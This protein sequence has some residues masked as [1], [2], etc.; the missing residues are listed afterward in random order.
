VEALTAAPVVGLAR[1]LH[2]MPPAFWV[3][4]WGTLVNRVGSFVT[5]F[6]ALYLTGERSFTVAEAGVVLSVLGA[7]SAISQPL[8]GV[9]A[10]RI[11]RRRTMVLG[12]S[13]AAGTLLLLGAARGWG[14][15]AT[16]AFAYGLCL[17]L[18]RPAVGAAVADLVP[19]HDRSRAFA[20]QFWAINLGFS[21]ATPLGG[22][23]ASRGYWLLFVLD[24]AASL[25]FAALILRGVPETRPLQ[26][27][28][29]GRLADAMRD[30]LLLALL[31]CS[32]AQATASFQTFVTLP[33]SFRAD[34][35]GPGTY[36]LAIALNGVMIIL[37]Q[38]LLLGTVQRRGRGG[39]LLTAL[40]LQ[41]VGLGMHALAEDVLGHV[42]AIFV[43]TLGEVLMAG[44]LGALVV[45]LAPLRVRGRYLGAFGS[46][47]GVAA[48]L[49][50]V[51]GTQ[52]LDR[53]GE[54]GLWGGA[55][56]VSVLAGFGLR[57]VSA[58]ADRRGPL[59]DT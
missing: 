5:P 37:L 22:F 28:T 30:R 8:G 14:A 35:L 52:V 11:G 38:P 31:L 7:G 36:G 59:R 48:L 9:L 17:E 26:T 4:W 42:V 45:S 6:L 41:G 55:L 54:G 39:L 43:W 20:L 53:F 1:H 44:Q 23:L 47:F 27:G 34:D 13:T 56:A 21:F 19:E 3:L 33:L 58:A 49:A 57:A 50:P 29:P 24:A 16:A 15:T 18:Y 46:S 40:V 10:D 12:L 32:V 51:S 2:G 25:G